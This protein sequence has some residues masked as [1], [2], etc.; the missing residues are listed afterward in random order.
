ME[1]CLALLRSKGFHRSLARASLADARAG[2]S[3]TIRSALSC[4]TF[5][6]A[7]RVALPRSPQIISLYSLVYSCPR[8]LL[9]SSTPV[10]VYS[11]QEDRVYGFGQNSI[12]FMLLCVNGKTNSVPKVTGLYFWYR[13]F[14]TA[15]FKNSS[16]R[17]CHI[18]HA[19]A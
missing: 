17:D 12:L 9:S 3:K 18:S 8:L 2:R 4:S 14:F 5:N 16:K 19:R 7:I 1:Q 13:C 10:L 6:S 11:Y 15:C